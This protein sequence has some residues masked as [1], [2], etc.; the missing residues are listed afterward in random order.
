[1]KTKAKLM[2]GISV[3]TAAVLAAGVTSTFAWLTTQSQ[4]TLTTGTM[5]VSTVSDIKINVK[6]LAFDTDATGTTGFEQD[7]TSVTDAGQPLGV[8]SSVDG[9][10]F[11]APTALK[12]NAEQYAAGDWAEVTTKTDWEEGS[13]ANGY[14]GYMKY[15][16]HVKADADP[17]GSTRTLKYKITPEVTHTKLAEAYRVALVDSTSLW[18]K[19]ETV[20]IHSKTAGQKTGWKYESSAYSTGNYTTTA[21]PASVTTL[22]VT[23][24]TAIDK[25][26]IFS[27]WVEG[28]DANAVNGEGGISG[29]TLKVDIEFSLE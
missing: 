18:A 10:K 14:V 12:G 26:Y 5:T 24:A 2:L 3:M 20:R 17:Q 1:M 23:T 7:V 21:I 4:A 6:K 13:Y 19:G 16:V 11:Y 9:V 15:G 28:E 29:Q 25:Y 22:G 27:V 8:V